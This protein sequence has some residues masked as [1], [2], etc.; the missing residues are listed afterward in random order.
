MPSSRSAPMRI[1]WPSSTRS[2]RQSPCASGCRASACSRCTGPGA[3]PMRSPAIASSARCCATSTGSS[4]VRRCASSSGRSCAT[5][6]RSTLR[7]RH[8]GR[9]SSRESEPVSSRVA[10]RR[11]VSVVYVEL[12]EITGRDA[13]LDPERLRVIQRRIFAEIGTLF[14]RHGG[15]PEVLPGDAALAAFG[16]DQAHED[17][18][19][20]AIRAACGVADVVAHAVAPFETELRTPCPPPSASPPTSSSPGRT[21]CGAPRSCA[22]QPGSRAVRHPASLAS[23]RT[24]ST[25]RRMPPR[26]SPSRPPGRTSAARSA[27]RNGRRT[28]P[29]RGRPAVRHSSTAM[30]SAR[31]S[32]T[33][34]SGQPP[35]DVPRSSHCSGRQASGS[36]GSCAS[37]RRPC[38]RERSWR[39]A[40]AC[41]TERARA[42]SRSTRWCARSLATMSRPAWPLRLADVDR[43]EQIADR[44]AIAIGAGG[45]GGPG[46]EIQWAFRRLLERVAD[47]APLVIAL[48]DLHWAEPWL[49]DLVEYLAGF[50]DGPIVIV[51]P[52]RPEL[53][54]E[55]PSWAGPEG[56]GQVA[57]LEPLSPAHTEELVTGLL[58]DQS[59]PP[60]TARRMS[61]SPRATRC[62]PSRSW[63]SRSSSR[64]RAGRRFPPRSARSCRSASTGCPR[65]SGTCS[66]ARRS[67]AP[68]STGSPR[69]G[70][71]ERR[72]RSWG[73]AGRCAPAGA[74]GAGGKRR[75][76]LAN[77]CSIANA[78]TCSGAWGALGM[79]H[80][81][82]RARRGR[83]VGG[84]GD[85]LLGAVQGRGT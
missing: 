34:W 9:A 2:P 7:R 31:Y 63:R 12:D 35:S 68:C 38:R 72:C 73:T 67:R 43:G 1:W 75:P 27:S 58:A 10:D 29:S 78:T 74:P 61:S 50:A 32:Q 14:R 40:A 44:V 24:P 22:S 5:T 25:S 82:R 11:L 30:R 53:L 60:G 36:R 51:A 62:S 76:R 28:I 37:S 16:I 3:R 13:E 17:D 81:A 66:R 48:D 33:R 79:D 77:D 39:S 21:G 4:R 70:T 20:R 55:R 69:R 65:T 6:P 19:A 18:A 47:D 49:L 54:E 64:S 46:E 45:R 80:P 41:P 71:R 26:T 8:A 84:A 23:T 56:P 59:P 85:Q 42:C 57:V 15:V 52:A 83:L